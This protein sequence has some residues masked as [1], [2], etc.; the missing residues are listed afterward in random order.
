MLIVQNFT[1]MIQTHKE[2]P[3]P[4]VPA[5]Q[6]HSLLLIYAKQITDVNGKLPKLGKGTG[7]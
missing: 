4:P 1:R 7:L 5:P 6:Y 3:V 2:Q